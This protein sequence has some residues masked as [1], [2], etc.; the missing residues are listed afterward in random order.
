VEKIEVKHQVPEESMQAHNLKREEVR[1][2]SRKYQ[3]PGRY[4][5]VRI[6]RDGL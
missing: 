2:P 1:E 4:E 5:T 3:R 6:E